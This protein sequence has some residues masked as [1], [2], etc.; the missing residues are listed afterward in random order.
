MA[1]ID[2][3]K[4]ALRLKS[5]AYDETELSLLIA[6]AVADLERVGIA[7]AEEDPLC[8][9]AVVFYCKANF[10]F[11]DDQEKWAAAYAALR[12]AMT[13]SAAYTDPADPENETSEES[14]DGE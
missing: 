13:L 4:A 11:A 8:R 6:A 10:G 2:D 5:T 3:V 9:H 7:Y 1:Q 14:G 12:D